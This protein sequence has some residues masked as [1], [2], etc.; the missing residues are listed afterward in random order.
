MKTSVAVLV[1]SLIGITPALVMGTP[2]TIAQWT[3]ENSVPTASGPYSPELGSGTAK[4]ERCRVKT[5][6][7]RQERAGG[8]VDRGTGVTLP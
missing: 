8:P 1:V 2:T 7:D 4:P 3:F 6:A 5:P